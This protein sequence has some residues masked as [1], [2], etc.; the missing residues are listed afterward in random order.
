MDRDAPSELAA[1]IPVLPQ[2][3]MEPPKGPRACFAGS[4]LDAVGCPEVWLKKWLFDVKSN[5]VTGS[6]SQADDLVPIAG[7]RRI[8][9]Y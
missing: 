6:I 8:G 9:A 2:Q 5:T 1:A 3:P 4:R 7:S